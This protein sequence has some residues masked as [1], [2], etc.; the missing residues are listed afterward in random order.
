MQSPAFSAL[1]LFDVAEF[2]RNEYNRSQHGRAFLFEGND[3]DINEWK[4]AD[5]LAT[6]WG[7]TS[8]RI[9]LLCKEGRLDGAVKKGHQWLIPAST[10]RLEKQKSGRR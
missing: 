8:R 10:K 6:E 7:L 3:M 1:V 4:T 5:E 2:R 9:Q